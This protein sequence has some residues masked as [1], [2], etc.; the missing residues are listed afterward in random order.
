MGTCQARRC[1][2]L[3]LP[4][5]LAQ[6]MLSVNLIGSSTQQTNQQSSSTLAKAQYLF[7]NKAIQSLNQYSIIISNQCSDWVSTVVNHPQH[8]K[9]PIMIWDMIVRTQL[10]NS[11]VYNVQ[12]PIHFTHNSLHLILLFEHIFGQWHMPNWLVW[13][14][15]KINYNLKNNQKRKGI[16]VFIKSQPCV[17]LLPGISDLVI[18]FTNFKMARA[19]SHAVIANQCVD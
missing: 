14:Q 7:H 8:N 15:Y 17:C 11:A 16:S 2:F 9:Q 6:E 10:P 13:I 19:P 12:Y 3:A 4:L 1:S 18:M 5:G